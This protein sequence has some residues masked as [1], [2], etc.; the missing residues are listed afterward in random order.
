MKKLSQF[1]LFFFLAA[2]S[3][4]GQVQYQLDWLPANESYR[5]SMV[6]GETWE[7]PYNMVST[8]Q[9]TLKVP[10]GG[11]EIA[12]VNNLITDV[13]FVANS[14]YNAP[15][16]STD[17]DYISFGLETL[18]T[19]KISFSSGTTIP[20]FT[21]QNVGNCEGTVRI[22]NNDDEF[23]PPNS[24]KANVGNS[25]T[26]L[27][28]GGDAYIGNTGEGV[29]CDFVGT[30]SIDNVATAFNVF[31]NP[32]ENKVNIEFTWPR[33]TAEMNFNVYDIRGQLVMNSA[34]IFQNGD[35]IV[36]M[37]VDKLPSGLYSLEIQGKDLKMAIDK[38]MKN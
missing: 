37:D 1:I 17:F 38:F 29:D 3:A 33:P 5:V 28:A 27:G 36:S 16:E 7:T 32:V 26:V 23:M 35:N 18:G 21:F 19:D 20:L 30:I 14:R 6:V 8:A 12:N 11:F 31:P 34:F 15:S 25:I 10:T 9:I 24:S 2:S 13:S 22:M 4:F